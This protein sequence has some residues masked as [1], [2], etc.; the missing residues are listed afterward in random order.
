M[1]DWKK[2]SSL[3]LSR[4]WRFPL[5]SPRSFSSA[6]FYFEIRPFLSDI[7][8]TCSTMPFTVQIL[9]IRE[10]QEKNR[11]KTAREASKRGESGSL[12]EDGKLYR[13]RSFNSIFYLQKS[14][15]KLCFLK[16]NNIFLWTQSS[17][18]QQILLRRPCKFHPK[19]KFKHVWTEHVGMAEKIR[20]LVSSYF[21][22][23]FWRN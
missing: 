10:Q 9:R 14:Y 12:T 17:R 5:L 4:R 20:L 18:S 8:E 11:E 22:S 1:D 2:V 7:P 3:N 6:W 23:S 15:F 13:C 21:G 16:K 19:E